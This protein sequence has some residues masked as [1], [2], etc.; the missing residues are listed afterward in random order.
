MAK[1]IGIDLGTTNSVMAHMRKKEAR[2]LENQDNDTLTPS[3]VHLTEHNEWLV[4][5]L[6]KA[7]GGVSP[8]A[9]VFSIKRFMGR[10]FDDPVIQQD[11]QRAPYQVVEADNGEVEVLL[12][13]RNFSPPEISAVILESMKADA[14]A[15][16][17][18]EVTHAVI[19][20]PAYFG[21]RQREVT[22]LAG[23]LA[24]LNVLR[25]TPEPTAASLAYGF[26][27]GMEDPKTVLVYDLGGGTFDVTVMFIAVGVFDDQGK[28]GDMHL[29]GDD[30]DHQ[31]MDWLVDQ[32]KIQHRVNLNDLPNVSEIRFQLKQAAEAAKIKLSRL[33]RAQIVIPGLL[34]TGGRFIDIDYELNRDELNRM[35]QKRVDESIKLVYDAIH[36]ANREPDD[37]DAILLVG[38][39]T[40]IPLV[41][42]SLRRPFGEKVIRAEINPMHCV[43]QGAA[44]QTYL[45]A[46]DS[47][48]AQDTPLVRCSK[49]DALNLEGRE[50]CRRCGKT[51]GKGTRPKKE[52]EVKVPDIECGSCG[53]RNP[54]G[55][56]TC[57][58]CGESLTGGVEELLERVPVPIGIMV[59][60]KRME[61]II[62]NTVYYP[63]QKPVSKMLHTASPGQVKVN[64]PVYEGWNEMAEEN[65]YLGLASGE[66]PAGLPENTNVDVAFSIDRSGILFIT[67]S[68]PE[69]PGVKIEARMNWKTKDTPPP[70]PPP[71]PDD[72]TSDAQSQLIQA[73][74]IESEG[75]GVVPAVLLNL[76]SQF[77]SQ[78]E[79]ALAVGDEQN[80]IA[81]CAR[82]EPLTSQLGVFAVLGL[83]R[84]LAR[85]PDFAANA[86][87]AKA[88]RLSQAV[89]KADQHKKAENIPG[90]AQVVEKEIIP[91]LDEMIKSSGKEITDI[92]G[93]LRASSASMRTCPKC[94]TPNRQGESRCIKCGNYL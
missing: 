45:P 60:G 77:S 52:P 3:V 46:E 33:Q 32:V 68:L 71:T 31:I 51:I 86:G 9:T 10:D 11:I 42:E 73:R 24:G 83:A 22:R 58:R 40:G 65:Q 5:K 36:M 30:F 56:V 75:Q 57:F 92:G 80:G 81:L 7:K 61:V 69:K 16:L 63:T 8:E 66:L 6:A 17:N 23:R 37:I 67:A 39:S 79:Q 59:E 54:A 1:M 74:L 44:I 90:I 2:V 62:D 28:T 15:M 64:M 70:P 93:L 48:T 94:G 76:L 55:Q 26:D 49:C 4:G 78:L 19:T 88:D 21:N 89:A 84:T 87:L 38:G 85:D 53:A 14:E 20:V 41:G 34:K 91:V 13:G 43:A 12:R 35:I 72:W 18:E 25:I 47:S 50:D 27:A 29:G 82:L